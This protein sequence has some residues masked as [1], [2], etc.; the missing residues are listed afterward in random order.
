MGVTCKDVVDTW[1]W[2]FGVPFNVPKNDL[3]VFAADR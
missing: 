2:L 1:F 3:F